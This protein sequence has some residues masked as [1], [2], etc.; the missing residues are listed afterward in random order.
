MKKIQVNN[1]K[2][3][4]RLY[5]QN[6]RRILA[7][8]SISFSLNKGEFLAI[9]GPSGAGKST[10]LK[11]IYRTYLPTAGEIIL[12]KEDGTITCVH[13]ALENEIIELRK[14]EIGYVSQ[15]LKALPRISALDLVAKPL[16]DLG[17]EKDVAREQAKE[18]LLYLGIKEELHNVSPLTFSG[19][20]QQRVNIAKAIIAPKK[21][22]LL[23]E[24]TASLDIAKKRLVKG[25]LKK[26]KEKGITVIGIF[27]ETDLIADIIDKTVVL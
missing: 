16:F 27:H 11:C 25:L 1:L 14:Y 17:V 15:F 2:K 6:N 23:D 13:N 21:L 4:F 7:F 26:L 8:D 20:E 9:L 5:L 19:G 18:M 3:E 12:Q 22:L 24:P 10:I